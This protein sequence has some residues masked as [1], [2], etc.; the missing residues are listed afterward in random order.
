[1]MEGA[2][3]EVHNKQYIMS[4]RRKYVYIRKLRIYVKTYEKNWSTEEG[5]NQTT[6][7]TQRPNINKNYL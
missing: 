2:H 6:H 5:V 4:G 3:T 7:H 1:M